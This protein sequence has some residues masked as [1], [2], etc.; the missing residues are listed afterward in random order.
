[1]KS[2]GTLKLLFADSRGTLY[3]H[4]HLRA[5]GMSGGDPVPLVGAV[6]IPYGARLMALPGWD[7]VGLDPASGTYEILKEVLIGRR[8]RRV[9][10]VAAVPPPGFLRLLNPSAVRTGEAPALPLWAYTAAGGGPHGDMIAAARVDPRR[11]WD[12]AHYDTPRLMPSIRKW[13]KDFPDN[14]IVRQLA[15]CATEYFCSTARNLFLAR[16]EA[17]LPLSRACN[18]RCVGCISKQDGPHPCSQERI[19]FVPRIEEGA[20]LAARHLAHAKDPIVS[21][22]QGCEGEPL[23]AATLAGQII[24]RTRA[25]TT[26]GVFNMNTNGSRPDAFAS[27]VD[28]GLGSVRVS[29]NSAIPAHY[30]AYFRQRSYGFNDVKR[31][32]KIAASRGVF[33]SINLLVYPGV[34]DTAGETR[35]L[36][37]FAKTTGAQF[38]QLRN[39][40]IDPALYP[41]KSAPP[42]GRPIGMAA[43]LAQMRDA[44]PAV[45][46]GC[47]NPTPTEISR[48]TG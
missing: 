6:P 4:P 19:E 5:T 43:W 9:C 2:A 27:L 15:R 39:L 34:T 22:G 40:S 18:S 16:Y 20:E 47:Y 24:R 13:L 8:W 3:A 32:V 45:G 42:R 14:R 38:V 21:F 17:A 25:S 7:P 41:V 12:T 46:F 37:S 1:V 11:R 29:L 26:R 44:L 35:A 31:T 30:D 23:T 48:F 10:A 33:T 28:A 36:I